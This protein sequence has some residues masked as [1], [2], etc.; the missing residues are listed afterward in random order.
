MIKN[1][2]YFQFNQCQF[3]KIRAHCQAY[4]FLAS[5]YLFNSRFY[6]FKHAHL[7]MDIDCAIICTGSFI[8]I[9]LHTCF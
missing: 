8:N 3:P 5:L 6:F 2:T 9:D 1:T 4:V 7:K